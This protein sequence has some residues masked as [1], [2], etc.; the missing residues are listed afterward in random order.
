[1]TIEEARMLWL[2]TFGSGWVSSLDLFNADDEVILAYKE[3]L[4]NE[5]DFDSFNN[6]IKIKCKS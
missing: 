1:M 3:L 6:T 2:L 5:M 4:K